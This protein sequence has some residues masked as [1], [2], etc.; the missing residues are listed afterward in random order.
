MLYIRLIMN[1]CTAETA[2]RFNVAFAFGF[3]I[4]VSFLLFRH[5]PELR[6]NY[7]RMILTD[8]DVVGPGRDRRYGRSGRQTVRRVI[9]LEDLALPHNARTPGS[10]FKILNVGTTVWGGTQSIAQQTAHSYAYSSGQFSLPL[11]LNRMQVSARILV[12]A[13]IFTLCW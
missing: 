9:G 3:T 13:G 7:G 11:W 4:I 1:S 2:S 8:R 12:L 10:G 5:K 6:L